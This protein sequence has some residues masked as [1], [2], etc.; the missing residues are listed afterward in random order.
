M[1]L[2][3]RIH[4]SADNWFNSATDLKTVHSEFIKMHDCILKYEKLVSLAKHL[5]L[6]DVLDYQ[7][8]LEIERKKAGIEIN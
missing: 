5:K 6:P 1:L 4:E 3:T 7:K 8:K 2:N